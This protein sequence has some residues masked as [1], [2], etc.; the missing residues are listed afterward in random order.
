[1]A[2]FDPD[3]RAGEMPREV[4]IFNAVYNTDGKNSP[5]LSLQFLG[6]SHTSAKILQSRIPSV[7]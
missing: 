3:W 5:C 1:M 4:R 6:S 7:S 2:R